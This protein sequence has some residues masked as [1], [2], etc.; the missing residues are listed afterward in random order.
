MNTVGDVS[1]R[2]LR[3]RVTGVETG[4]H[5][6]GDITVE[7]GYA[8][9]VL[10]GTQTHVC[11]VEAIRV[12]LT[13]Q[14]KRLVQGDTW[15][16]TLLF[17]KPITKVTAHHGHIETV[18]SCRNRSVGGEDIGGANLFKGCG[19]ISACSNALADTLKGEEACMSLIQ[20]GDAR[21]GDATGCTEGVD[22][23]D[24]TDTQDDFLLDA[25]FRVATIETVGNRTHVLRI[26]FNVCV[27]ENQRDTSDLGHPEG[28][29]DFAPLR[30]CDRDSDLLTLVIS[31]RHDG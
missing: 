14:L 25:V 23:A 24:T 16:Q 5:L 6:T 4:E 7:L 15:A 9:G 12:F 22:G 8:V 18:D 19:I 31:D 27:Q 20:V 28:N 17:R 1:D 2:D 11:H 10:G 29:L 30:E 13:A 21:G 26:V 3:R